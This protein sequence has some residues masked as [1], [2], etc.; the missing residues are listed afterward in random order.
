MTDT[1]KRL[2]AEYL[3]EKAYKRICNEA[4]CYVDYEGKDVVID[5]YLSDKSPLTPKETMAILLKQ[6]IDSF[7]NESI[8]DME[9]HKYKCL[10][11]EFGNGEGGCTVPFCEVRYKGVKK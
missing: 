7:N 9:R 6:S 8:K 3:L 1:E 2:Q 5:R 11:C 4:Q 10:S